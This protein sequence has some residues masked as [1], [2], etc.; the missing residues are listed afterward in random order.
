MAEQKES[1]LPPEEPSLDQLSLRHDIFELDDKDKGNIDFYMNHNGFEPFILERLSNIKFDRSPEF[2]EIDR[3][4]SQSS[5]G[6]FED[7]PENSVILFEFIFGNREFNIDKL[8]EIGDI[9]AVRS[10]Y[11]RR[12]RSVVDYCI[13]V[14]KKHMQAKQIFQEQKELR[15]AHKLATLNAKKKGKKLA[16]FPDRVTYQQLLT[17][18]GFHPT[19]K[20]NFDQYLN[21]CKEQFEKY[22]VTLRVPKPFEEDYY[23]E[24]TVELY[25]CIQTKIKVNW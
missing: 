17:D 9:S 25:K 4:F 16:T 19:R 7:T 1:N 15:D 12:P 6:L 5:A 14:W 11:Y 20:A 3:M 24:F 22:W 13:E 8:T 2:E 18:F 21:Q 10:Q 23:A